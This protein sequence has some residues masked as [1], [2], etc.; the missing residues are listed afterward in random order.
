M[1]SKVKGDGSDDLLE[2]LKD[3]PYSCVHNK[4]GRVWWYFLL[5]SVFSLIACV[6]LVLGWRCLSYLT[7]SCCRRRRS[8]KAILLPKSASEISK[9]PGN[10]GGALS[11]G[12]QKPGSPSTSAAG[13]PAVVGQQEIG[14]T[15]EAKDW[16]G[17]LISG[18]T[19]TGRVLVSCDCYSFA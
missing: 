2:L 3:D 7:E 8:N 14:W 5:S 15:S 9:S 19:S 1:S 17:Q 6:L 11:P 16:A 18:Q 10:Q 13:P 4:Q 12:S